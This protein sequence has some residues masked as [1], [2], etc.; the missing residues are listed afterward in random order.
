LGTSLVGL[1][2]PNF[3]MDSLRKKINYIGVKYFDR[4]TNLNECNGKSFLEMKILYFYQYFSTSEGAWGT[5]VYEFAKNW[6]KEGHEVTVVTSVYSKSDLK[7]NKLVSLQTV[8]GIQV[9][10]INVLIDNKQSAAKRISTFL[11]YALISSWYAITQKADIVIAS[12][13]P[14]TVGIPGLLA[15]WIRRRKLVFE[16]RDLWPEGAVKMGLLKNTSLISLAYWFEKV[17]YRNS[18]VVIGLSPGIQKDIQTRFPD[19][20]VESVTNA[21]NIDLFSSPIKFKGVI[22]SSYALYFGNIGQVNHSDYLLDAAQLLLTKGRGDIQLLLIGEGQLKDQLKERV[23]KEKIRNVSFL[24]LMPKTALIGYVQ[25]ALASV[26]PLKPLPVFDT[27]SPNKLFESMAA[28][29]PIIQTT[30]GWIKDFI[31]QQHVGFTVDGN[32]PQELADKL[33]LLKDNP[34]MRN[35]MASRSR[36]TAVQYFDKDYLAAKMLDILKSVHGK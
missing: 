11:Q 20:K 34:V 25:H 4:I 32:N 36:A 19:C 29:V 3:L 9:R 23:Q 17:C 27:S 14:I 6:V 7:S 18:S 24:D 26:I 16:A 1:E 28:G 22:G 31:E 5:R 2:D 10:V 15:R 33:I 8:E 12:S 35:E 30:H 13:G 21:A